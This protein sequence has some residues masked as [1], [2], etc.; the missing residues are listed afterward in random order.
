MKARLAPPVPAGL[1][2]L[3]RMKSLRWIELR[4][5]DLRVEVRLTPAGREA[6]RV[7]V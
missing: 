4:G 7:P 1:G 3:N 6:M 2:M 5:M